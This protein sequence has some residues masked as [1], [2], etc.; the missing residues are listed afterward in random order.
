[1]P[2]QPT[3][4]D[5]SSPFAQRGF[6][7]AAIFLAVV[8]LLG[9]V[10]LVFGVGSDDD[11]QGQGA[12]NPPSPTATTPTGP[13][14]PDPDESACGLPAGRQDVPAAPP[15]ATWKL[16]GTLAAPSAPRIGPGIDDGHRRLCF[17]HSPTGALFAAVNFLAALNRSPNDRDLFAELTANGAVRDRALALLDGRPPADDGTRSQLAGFRVAAYSGGETTIDLAIRVTTPS[18]TSGLSHFLAP[19]RWERGDW[20]FVIQSLERPYTA[21]AIANLSGYVPWGGA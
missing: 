12:T 10:V 4:D 15:D 8:V 13:T 5:A 9:V 6:V 19:L 3:N 21:E 17:A 20:K 16:V 7:F 18:G 1:M 2:D 14:P 11:G